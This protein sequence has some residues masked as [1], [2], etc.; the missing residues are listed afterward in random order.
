MTSME[1]GW[2]ALLSASLGAGLLAAGAAE[3]QQFA[4][5]KKGGEFVFAEEAKVNSL[6][7]YASATVSTRNIT[8]NIFESLMTRDERFSPMPE[9]AQ[10]VDGSADGLTYVFKLRQGIKFHNGKPMSSAD[11]VASFERYFKVGIDRGYLEAIQRL[12]APDPLT[13]I[14]HMKAPQPTF[15]ENLSSFLVPV[16]IVPAEITNA[17]PLQMEPIGTGPFQYVE[18]I[19]DSHVTLK[20]YD[21]YTPDTRYKD[22]DGFGGYKVACV[23]SVKFRIVTEPGARVAGLETGEL[24]GVEDI[25]TKSVERLKQ[26]KNIVLKNLENFWIPV[27]EANTNVPPTDNLKVRQAIQA[28]LDMDEIMDAASDG[29]YTLQFGMQYP[30]QAAYTDVGK[31]TY[32]QKNPA[33][34][35]QLLAEAG[36]KGEEMVLLTNRD[37]TVMY[38]ASL[39][40]SE[41]LKA[42]G[43]NVKLLVLD[44][45]AAAQMWLKTNTGWNWFFNGYANGPYIGP[46]ATV[47][48]FSAPQYQYKPKTPADID[49]VFDAAFD[50]MVNGNTFEIRKAAFA[51][52]QARLFEQ[53]Y[54]LPFGTMPKVQA[55]R[56]NV[57]N[58]RPYRIPRISNVYF[59]G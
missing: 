14:V 12:E 39:V 27:A 1:R 16:V 41:Q 24:H 54:V 49:K 3:A 53:V 29:A 28:A 55:V 50:Q 10:S 52:A 25:P 19:A 33:K 18:F 30:F 59:S 15:L 4:C 23:D 34:A 22:I 9:L 31:E 17:A 48:Q 36:Y 11:V 2:L 37:Y 43:M 7:Q 56:S 51:K 5:P 40:M 26:N 8:L 45:P 6:D 47:R 44:W 46:I 35:K 21:G 32:N 20:R 58:F 13:F 38:N 42:I 57:Q